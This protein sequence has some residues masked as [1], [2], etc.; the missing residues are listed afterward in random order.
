MAVAVQRAGPDAK[1]EQHPDNRTI[2]DEIVAGHA[3]GM[4][5]RLPD[6]HC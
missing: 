1:L 6:T 2:F 3:D 5:D 4:G